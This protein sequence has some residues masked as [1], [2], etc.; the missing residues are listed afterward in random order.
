MVS[1]HFSLYACSS[2]SPSFM[3]PGRDGDGPFAKDTIRFQARSYPLEPG[4]A[5]WSAHKLNSCNNSGR[6]WFSS[7]ITVSIRAYYTFLF[8][9]TLFYFMG[10]ADFSSSTCYP[11]HLSLLRLSLQANEENVKVAYMGKCARMP[12]S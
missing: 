2:Y 12:D 8:L 9:A 3:D 1:V 5:G 11:F 6:C 7:L 10:S 4:V